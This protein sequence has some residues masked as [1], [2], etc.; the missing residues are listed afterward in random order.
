MNDRTN[1][2]KQTR[3]VVCCGSGGVGKTT[4]SAAIGL[5]GALQGKKTVVLTIDPARRLAD[6]LGISALNMEA[7]QVQ[8]PESNG[9][10]TGELYA[11]MVD[12][13]RTFDRLIEQYA[14][15]GLRERILENRYY[16]HLSNN[17]AGSHEYMAMERL[18]EI[19]NENQFDLIVL[20][21]PPSRRALDFLEAPQRVINLLGH[22]YFLK[23]FKPYIK[24]GQLS[25]RLFNLLAMPVLRAV[26]QVVGGQTI[27]D[28]FSFFQLFNDVIFDGFSR[29]A[30]A[31]ES[32]L[33][34][35]MSVFF[36]VATPQEYPMQEAVYLYRQLKER[37]MPFG[38][39]IVNR[40]HSDPVDS[41]FDIKKADRKERLE[42]K[43]ADAEIFTR[44]GIA[45]RMDRKLAKID[46]AAID[47]LVKEEMA[48]PDAA[49]F[50]IRFA[51]ETVNDISGLRII[52]EQ[53]M[54][55]CGF[56]I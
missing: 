55:S 22:P 9:N 50:P 16:Q 14:S 51:D 37:K 20:D 56:G 21:T 33:S 12:A 3:I 35:P 42:K 29:R 11:M 53:L 17:M 40:V 7:Q 52:G 48:G 6:A 23:L 27:S 46:A 30:A 44:L 19:Y 28:I 10:T 18:Y 5:L 47:R 8:L 24:A 32:L 49:V 4:I 54:R 26:G 43:I 13:K 34:D 45:D 31:V 41:P 25:G 38:G 15:N 2:P 39:F 36:A 1:P